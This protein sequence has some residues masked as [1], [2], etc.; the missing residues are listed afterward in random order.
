[1]REGITGGVVNWAVIFGGKRLYHSTVDE[2]LDC[3][4]FLPIIAK[5]ARKMTMQVSLFFFF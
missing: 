5:A 1:M 4:Q 2:H 3:Y